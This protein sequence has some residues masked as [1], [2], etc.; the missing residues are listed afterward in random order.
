MRCESTARPTSRSRTSGRF[1]PW[2][3]TQSAS[4][5]A[6]GPL[7]VR[8]AMTPT[9]GRQWSI[10]IVPWIGPR[11][12]DCRCCSTSTAARA[13]RVGKLRAVVGSDLRRAHGS[14]GGGASARRCGSSTLLPSDT[15][16]GGASQASPS[17]TSPR[18][19]CRPTSSAVSTTARLRQSGT[20]AW[21]R[22]ACPL[23]CRC[24]S[25]PWRSLWG[26]GSCSCRAECTRTFASRY[27][28]T[29]ALRTIGMA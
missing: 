28:G 3:S 20:R 14:G 4:L 26:S 22:S 9:R 24:S 29:T 17:A 12:V 27:T 6:I 13:V 8:R 19:R 25:A 2:A 5:S 23:C 10:W 21:V 15:R 18:R 7:R 16:G 1:A 11:S